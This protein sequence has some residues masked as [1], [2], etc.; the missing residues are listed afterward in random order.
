MKK[1]QIL[2]VHG[3]M[4][5]KS[6]N[7]YLRYLRTKKVSTEKKIYWAGDYLEKK[8]GKKFKVIAPRMP[9]SDN[10]SIEIGRSFLRDTCLF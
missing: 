1:I 7:D 6:E 8:L 10:A 2:T 9:L 4:T 5:F 3:G